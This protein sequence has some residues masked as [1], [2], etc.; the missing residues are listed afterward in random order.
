VLTKAGGGAPHADMGLTAKLCE[1]LGIVTV[2]QVGPPNSA[3]ERTVESATLFN[4]PEVD[5]ILF[6][7]GGAYFQLPASP[8]ERII[9]PSTTAAESLRSCLRRESAA[10]PAS[11]ALSVSGP[12]CIEAKLRRS[13][14]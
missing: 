9:A 11:K 6:N 1:E 2:V 10:S 7:S 4:Y 3:P 5:G 12:T 8:V 14:S 13:S